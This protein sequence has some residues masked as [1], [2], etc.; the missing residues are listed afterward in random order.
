[1]GWESRH[2]WHQTDWELVKTKPDYL[3]HPEPAWLYLSDPEQYAYDNFAAVKSHLETGTPF[4]S[5]NVPED[6]IHSDWTIEDMMAREGEKGGE[7]FYIV[8]QS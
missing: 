6:H 5:T 8:K 2:R 3:K 7:D 4:K 1:M